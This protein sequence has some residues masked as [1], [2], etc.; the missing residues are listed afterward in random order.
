MLLDKYRRI[1]LFLL[2]MVFS[3]IGSFRKGYAGEFGDNVYTFFKK[4]VL[5][6]KNPIFQDKNNEFYISYYAS[7][8]R[9]EGGDYGV[10]TKHF[11]RFVHSA[12]LHY[13]QPNKLLRIHGRLSVGAYTWHGVAGE[14]RNLYKAYGIEVIQEVF[15]G[16]SDLYVSAGIGPSF[17]IGKKG[18]LDGEDRGL[19]GFNFSSVIKIGHVFDCGMILE[20]AYH[21]YSNGGL[22]RT[23]QGLD[24]IG[25]AVGYVF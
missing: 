6:E 10:G 17:A 14:Y 15:F 12:Q 13:A 25:V 20:L 22:G 4:Y 18:A 19:T 8:N 11:E 1:L 3:S 23:N 2:L 9:G 21:H 24:M 16:T 5:T 7:F